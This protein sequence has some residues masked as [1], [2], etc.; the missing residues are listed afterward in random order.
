MGGGAGD[1]EAL[2]TALAACDRGNANAAVLGD[3]NEAIAEVDGVGRRG[4]G[5]TAGVEGDGER[6]GAGGWRRSECGG[7]KRY[8]T[9]W[10]FRLT[11]CI[12]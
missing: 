8:D 11:V 5:K 1:D 4:R 3:L 2:D 12:P 9:T 10:G 7:V 6:R